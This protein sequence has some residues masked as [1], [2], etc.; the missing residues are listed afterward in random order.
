VVIPEFTD[1]IL[2]SITSESV[3]ELQKELGIMVIQKKVKIADFIKGVENGDIIEAGGFGTAAVIS[4]V[5]TY[6][7]ED[8]RELQVGTGQIGEISKKIYA[9]Y[10]GI[11]TGRVKGPDGWLK[12]VEKNLVST[13]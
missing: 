11:Q 2:R 6:V 8:G 9:H 7:F 4:A 13:Y 5:G 1:T 10:T 12:K 3:I